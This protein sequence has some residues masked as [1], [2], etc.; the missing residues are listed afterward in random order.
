ML[1]ASA[2]LAGCEAETIVQGPPGED[3]ETNAAAN[4]NVELPP[5][6]AA[7]KIY[8]CSGDNSVIYVDWLSDKKTANVRTEKNGTPMQVAAAAEG[9]PMTGAGGLALTGTQAG[10]SISV[11]LPGQ[12]AKTCKA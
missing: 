7:S 6:I 12:A 9:E 11:T 1:V 5:S 10:A 3:T 8:R 2:A 4:A